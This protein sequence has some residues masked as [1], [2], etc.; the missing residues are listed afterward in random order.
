MTTDIRPT[1][2]FDGIRHQRDGYRHLRVISAY[3]Y[4]GAT[5]R[6]FAPIDHS[7]ESRTILVHTF[8]LCFEGWEFDNADVG[9]EM[10]KRWLHA[11][12]TASETTRMELSGSSKPFY[13]TVAEEAKVIAD[14][15][16]RATTWQVMSNSSGRPVIR[17]WFSEDLS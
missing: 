12:T 1:S 4:G 17:G 2:C 3:C 8:D 13:G 6:E 16:V 10:A 5:V 7:T 14:Y 11:K 15:T 9:V